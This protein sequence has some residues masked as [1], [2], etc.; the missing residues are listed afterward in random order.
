[1]DVGI[2]SVKMDIQSE[3]LVEIDLWKIE[4]HPLVDTFTSVLS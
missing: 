1:M 3:G 4:G 2:P